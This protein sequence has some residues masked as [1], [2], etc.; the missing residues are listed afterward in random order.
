MK[1]IITIAI[2]G[3]VVLVSGCLHAGGVTGNVVA[4]EPISFQEYCTNNGDMFMTMPPVIDGIPTGGA[5]CPGCMYGN[6]HY[7]DVAEYQ[8]AKGII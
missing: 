2:L 5:A 8:A 1:S 6:S 3:L 4:Q 7:C